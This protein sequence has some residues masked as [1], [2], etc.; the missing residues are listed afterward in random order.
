M[1][2]A[3]ALETLARELSECL[4]K[5]R[6]APCPGPARTWGAAGPPG[7]PAA[8]EG[9]AR[10]TLGAGQSPSWGPPAETVGRTTAEL[11]RHKAQTAGHGHEPMDEFFI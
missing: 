9:Y 7:T 5:S 1:G 11:S 6:A 8:R 4:P 10:R 2:A 3:S